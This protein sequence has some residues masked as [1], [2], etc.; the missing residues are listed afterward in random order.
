[1][2]KTVP[3]TETVMTSDFVIRF[4]CVCPTYVRAGVCV[5]SSLREWECVS[6]VGVPHACMCVCEGTPAH[7]TG[8][9]THTGGIVA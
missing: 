7:V 1:M 8:C 6:S 4:V 5:R 3:S 9:Y 2:K